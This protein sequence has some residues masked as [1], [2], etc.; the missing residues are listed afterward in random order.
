MQERREGTE[1]SQETKDAVPDGY[2]AGEYGTNV[3]LKVLQLTR[4]YNMEVWVCIALG[5]GLGELKFHGGLTILYNSVHYILT[6]WKA[7]SFR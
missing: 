6:T 5:I 4:M 3:N 2:K 7:R 1:E